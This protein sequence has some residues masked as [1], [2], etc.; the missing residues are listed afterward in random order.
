M[1]CEECRR[2]LAEE[3]LDESLA[4]KLEGICPNCQCEVYSMGFNSPGPVANEETLFRLLVSPRDYDPTTDLIS[5]QPFEKLFA[6]GLS[7]MRSIGSNDDFVGMAEENLGSK[8][9]SPFRRVRALCS[10]L[11]KEIRSIKDASDHQSFC[12]YD[13]IVPRRY[14]AGLDPISTHAGV[15]QRE[16][17]AGVDGAKRLNKDL[18]L[19]AYKLFTKQHLGVEDF[20]DHLFSDINEK[21]ARGDFINNEQAT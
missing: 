15:F 19:E 6:T 16:I 2:L 8:P 10:A 3:Y 14:K 5:K 21:A 7:V 17:K 18:A 4:K 1:D 9:D 13:Q 20:R 11:A 12:I